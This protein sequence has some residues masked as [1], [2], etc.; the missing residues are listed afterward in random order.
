M[1]AGSSSP[2]DSPRA[3]GGGPGTSAGGTRSGRGRRWSAAGKAPA[4]NLSQRALEKMA[5]EEEVVQV[6]ALLAAQGMRREVISVM[7]GTGGNRHQ[8]ACQL[9]KTRKC[10]C[11]CFCCRSLEVAFKL[12]KMRGNVSVVSPLLEVYHC[13]LKW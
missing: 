9:R 5:A 8:G 7:R 10:I 13:R 6:Q 11:V 1:H 2:P 4:T 3:P 12:N